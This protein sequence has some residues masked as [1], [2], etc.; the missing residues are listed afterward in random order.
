MLFV[1]ATDWLM[2]S[3]SKMTGA[4]RVRASWGMVKEEDKITGYPEAT[5]VLF[6][7]QRM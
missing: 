6:L 3:F 5:N 4:V 2:M 1:Q 7:Y